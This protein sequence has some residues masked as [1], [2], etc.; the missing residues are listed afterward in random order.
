MKIFNFI[1]EF[2]EFKL[3]KFVLITAFVIIGLMIVLFLIDRSLYHK[4]VKKIIKRYKGSE[5]EE[6]VSVQ[7]KKPTTKG[8]GMNDSP[9]R[10]RKSGLTWG[11]GNI[12]GASAKRGARKS[13]LK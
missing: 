9:F 1:S 6:N 7:K 4:K 11:G 10:E 8:W 5:K 12:K 2:M 13:F 3:N